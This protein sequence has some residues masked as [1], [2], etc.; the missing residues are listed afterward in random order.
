V[1]NFFLHVSCDLLEFLHF[2]PHISG[3][4]GVKL[5]RL[6]GGLRPHSVTL[7][8]GSC[9]KIDDWLSPERKRAQERPL[10]QVERAL[11]ARFRLWIKNRNLSDS[12]IQFFHSCYELMK[13][14]CRKRRGEAFSKLRFPWKRGTM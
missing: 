13:T 7:G 12:S 8:K 5:E 6:T 9:E 4:P 14:P 2:H 1:R 11:R 10:H 3:E